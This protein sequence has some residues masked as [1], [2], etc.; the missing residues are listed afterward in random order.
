MAGDSA[1]LPASALGWINAA[2]FK[3]YPELGVGF[4]PVA[5]ADMPYDRAYFERF[6]AQANT[7]LGAK[8]MQARVK[9]VREHYTGP[10]VDVGIGSG[11]FI[12]ARNRTGQ[13]TLGFDINAAG[14]DWLIENNCLLNPYRQPVEAISLWDVMEHLEDFAPLLCNVTKM[15]FVAIPLFD[16]VQHVLRSKHF[17]KDEH[18]WYFTFD[19]LRRAFDLCGFEMLAYNAE[20][21]RLGRDGIHSFC[22]KRRRERREQPAPNEGG[23][24]FGD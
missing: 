13:Q 9:F 4:Y 10:L 22:F 19:G 3:W 6:A 2:R 24:V 5:K 11:A 20:E 12:E 23:A 15:V 18:F 8:L 1:T 17:R 21:T 16:S 14:V 7:P